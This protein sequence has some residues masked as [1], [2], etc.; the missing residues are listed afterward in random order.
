MSGDP[1]KAGLWADADVYYTTNLAAV[2][3]PDAAT[4][5]TA[6]WHLVGLLDGAAGFESEGKFNKVTDHY[7]WGGIMIA[8]SRSQWVETK[9]FSI[10]E[11]NVYTR[12]LVYPGSAAGQ[13]AIPTIPQIKIAFETRNG[14]KTRRVVSTNYAQVARDG[15][16]KETEDDLTTVGLIATVFA[17]TDGSKQLWTE[18]NKPNIVSIALSPL[19]LALSLAGSKIKTIVATATY[20]D[21]TTGDVTLAANWVSGTPA[22]AS[23]VDGYV[24][25]LVIG[26]SSISCNYGGVTSTA[27]CVAT[28]AA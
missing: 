19:T 10:L 20:S 26:T 8:T 9:K 21:T 7:G 15:T 16:I 18:L 12:A 17:A 24:T 14:G 13:I 25:G 3:P 28:V 6:D 4:P 11:D 22:N 23:V 5:F 1:T 27:P 2:T